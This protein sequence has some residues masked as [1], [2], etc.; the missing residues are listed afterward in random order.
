MERGACRKLLLQV[1]QNYVKIRRRLNSLKLTF[2]CWR[3]ARPLS[4]PRAS[5]LAVTTRQPVIVVAVVFDDR[6]DRRGSVDENQRSAVRSRRRSAVD[7]LAAWRFAGP[8]TAQSTRQNIFAYQHVSVVAR[9]RRSRAGASAG[10]FDFPAGDR[11]RFR[12][13]IDK[14]LR[15]FTGPPGEAARPVLVA[16]Q[17]VVLMASVRRL[18]A[19]TIALLG[20][21]DCAML[22]RLQRTAIDIC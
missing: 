5:L 3:A 20:H 13:P 8:L 14:T 19:E 4:V 9:V 21:D 22:Q 16:D 1:H 15:M 10:N 2:T 12:T 18:H 6:P 7:V 11:R 17:R